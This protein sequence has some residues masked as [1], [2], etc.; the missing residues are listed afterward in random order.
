MA[1]A[2]AC[3]S[4]L[5][6]AWGADRRC[7][8]EVLKGRRGTW[9]VL[10]GPQF[11]VGEQVI[12]AQAIDRAK[13]EIIYVTN[14]AAIV[15]SGDGGCSWKE[16]YE[17]PKTPSAAMPASLEVGRIQRLQANRGLVVAAVSAPGRLLGVDV[18]TAVARSTDDGQTW[19]AGGGPSLLPGAP[20]PIAIAPGRDEVY[21]AA[22][23]LVQRSTDGAASFRPTAPL[24]TFT[25]IESLVAAPAG[26]VWAKPAGGS[27]FRSRD[28]GQ[29]W[30]CYTAEDGL[31]APTVA[32]PALGQDGD[33]MFLDTNAVTGAIREVLS[34]TNGGE[35]FASLGR[36][37]VENV[38]GDL[39]SLDGQPGTGDVVVTTEETIQAG[40]AGVFRW[41]PRL[42]R[43]VSIDEFA[44]APLRDAESPSAAE[45][46]VRHFFH[47]DRDVVI[48]EEAPG[49]AA[50]L[51]V[52]GSI[53]D[54]ENPDAAPAQ[55]LPEHTEVRVRAGAS[56]TLA[57]R[58]ELP[59]R[60][61]TLD[62]FF[63][64]DTSTSTEGY[65]NGM[66]AGVTG[67]ARGLASAGVD[68]RFGLGE[69]QDMLLEHGLRYALRAQIGPADVLT[70]A[71]ARLRTAGGEEP[72]YTA[73]DQVLTGRGVAAPRT[74]QP[75]PAGQQA[76][77]REHSLRT[78][79]LMADESFA[80]DPD[81]ADRNQ[82]VK[83]LKRSGVGF[84]GV[85]VY[86]PQNSDPRSLSI[87]SCRRLLAEPRPS[88]GGPLGATRLRCQLDDLAR[89]AGTVAP[90]GGVDCDGDGKVDVAA[91]RPLVCP[92]SRASS[93][94]IVAVADPLRRLLLALTDA[95]PVALG[96]ASS[97]AVVAPHGDYGRLD[98]KRAHDLRFDATFSCGADDG[99]KRFPVTLAAAVAGRDVAQAG[100]TLV[101]E[102][103]PVAAVVARKPR[104]HRHQA[105]APPAAPPAPAAA[106]AAPAPAPPAPAPASVPVP[107]T[108]PAYV[109]PP[110]PASAS[111]PAPAQ[112][113]A[114]GIAVAAKPEAEPARSLVEVDEDESGSLSFSNGALRLGG[115][116]ALLAVG[117]VW[118]SRPQ[119][120]PRLVRV[121]HAEPVRRRRRR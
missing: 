18:M 36:E 33:V 111:A 1:A 53:E 63:L 99:G 22:G 89:A 15:R 110:A 60:S 113:P 4:L 105:P 108:P 24:G 81:G 40:S 45:P 38:D 43:L 71:L 121:H 13:P 92:V 95:Q 32:G 17:L 52:P 16:S 93:T 39:Q 57:Y 104:R 7:G 86:N 88:Q 84:I 14:G 67:I 75:V 94:S 8:A 35:S 46:R 87:A 107:V 20:G 101:C 117:L 76:R 119:R 118:P 61:S 102:A 109:P 19:D 98:L 2:A 42:K 82:V 25:R 55:L 12:T 62:T 103:A 66:R 91:G 90:A 69:Y 6:S 70:N 49:G 41:Q 21:A 31:G 85:L 10:R 30:R 115:I 112:A 64:L 28:H 37:S 68:A 11:G 73:V 100:A 114:T 59:A 97:R 78:I 26:E 48:Y 79:V 34:S 65:I 27:A 116:A 83:A 106:P 51:P 50:A 96:S 44:L 5:A 77:W 54:F 72:G 120:S 9:T 58:L 56:R 23:G 74:A 29:T 3:A 80:P 47:T